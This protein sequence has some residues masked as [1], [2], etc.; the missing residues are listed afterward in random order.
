MISESDNANAPFV[1]VVNQAFARKFMKGTDPVGRRLDLGGAAV[2]LP[3]PYTVIGVLGDQIDERVGVPAEPMVFL[4]HQQV[5]TTSLFYS[6]L[7]GT[8]VAFLVRTRGDIPLQNEM[9]VVFRQTAPGFAIDNF[10]SMQENVDD[11]TF[12]KRLGLYLVASFAGLAVLMV[13]AGLYGVLSQVVGYRQREISIRMA[14]GATRGSVAEMIIRQGSALIAGG[15]MAGVLL[16]AALGRLVQ[17]FLYA[18]KP[19]DGWA[20]CGAA[21][22]LVLIGLASAL[23]PAR[24]AAGLQPMRALREE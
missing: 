2:G 20:Y 13:V 7:L 17:N 18:V 23:V 6:P 3:Q 16:A 21:V 1:A 9:K 19:L 10:Q 14:M 12:G 24:R 8:R 15:L 4:P 11:S 22:A 5:P